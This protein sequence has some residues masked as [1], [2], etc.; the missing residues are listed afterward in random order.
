MTVLSFKETVDTLVKDHAWD[1]WYALGIM[2][3]TTYRGSDF[4]DS[5]GIIVRWL[6]F[7]S[8]HMHTFS[9]AFKD[10]ESHNTWVFARDWLASL[11]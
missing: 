11:V 6:G 7:N 10:V 2:Y 4:A 5:S 8:E 9:V 3:S 1:Y